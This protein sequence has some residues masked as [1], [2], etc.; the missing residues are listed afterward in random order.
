MTVTTITITQ[1][2]TYIMTIIIT[3]TDY[4][5][6]D[7]YSITI[8]PITILWQHLGH[9]HHFSLQLLS[10]SVTYSHYS[11]YTLRVTN[12]R[13]ISWRYSQW[14]TTCHHD[15]HSHFH[16]SHQH[17]QQPQKSSSVFWVSFPRSVAAG[18][19]DS[20]TIMWS[21]VRIFFINMRFWHPFV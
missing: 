17:Y 10:P 14:T 11:T 1:Y 2:I 6:N 7:H 4:H 9:E 12:V 21:Y 13:I 3:V 15:I 8:M 20:Q 5:H 16:H 19:L 18:G